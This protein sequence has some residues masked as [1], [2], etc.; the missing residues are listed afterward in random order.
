MDRKERS[1]EAE[2]LKVDFQKPGKETLLPNFAVQRKRNVEKE[3][4]EQLLWK[5][6]SFYFFSNFLRQKV[7]LK[8]GLGKEASW[9]SLRKKAATRTDKLS[10]H[11]VRRELKG[12]QGR[13]PPQTPRRCLLFSYF[14]RQFVLRFEQWIERKKKKYFC[15]HAA[16]TWIFFFPPIFFSSYKI[17]KEIP[18]V[19]LLEG[20]IF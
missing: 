19:P 17:E 18:S 20:K 2:K 15:R 12:A 10:F 9:L 1:S 11:S 16:K 7:S 4:R 14:P 8:K 13:F 3:R 5:I 6:D